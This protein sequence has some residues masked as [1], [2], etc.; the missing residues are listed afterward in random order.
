MRKTVTALLIF[1]VF[2]MILPG[3]AYAQPPVKVVVDGRELSFDVPPTIEGNRVLVPFRKIGEAMGVVVGWNPDTRTVYGIKGRVRV[4]LAI[5][6]TYA[7][8]NGK[9][10][11]L[12]VPAVIRGNRTLVPLRFFSEAFGA[13]VGW[14]GAGRVVTIITAYRTPAGPV[15]KKVLGYYYSKS[16][17]DF[18]ANF[19]RMTHAAFKWYTLDAAGNLTYRD[20]TRWIYV[21]EGYAEVL[22]TAGDNKVKTHALVFE[23]NPLRL[24][25][26]LNDEE[27]RDN[28][29]E[30]IVELA[31][32]GGFNGVDIDF[33]N[34]RENDR[35]EFNK[36]IE[37]LASELHKKDKALSISL[38]VKTEKVD[39]H[40]AYDYAELGKHADL[41]I[42]MAYDKN[43]A[44]PEPQAA[45]G[46]VEEVVDYAVARI[47]AEKVLLGIGFYGYNWSAAGRGTV[48]LT[49][50]DFDSGVQFVDELVERYKATP[51]WD[52]D[53]MMSTFEYYDEWG[54]H[55]IVWYEDEK[56][57]QAKIDLVKNKNIGG[58]ALWRLGYITPGAWK[59]IEQNFEIKR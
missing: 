55:H 33:E 20:D 2:W 15:A 7:L 29:I 37:K 54:R 6:S 4:E 14:D 53:A 5:E 1:F 8:V 40:K 27:K 28:L 50:Q 26:V 56:S 16:Y 11:A 57:L 18:M 13:E 34:I 58:I 39:W 45:I 35:E 46:W 36:F 52:E 31:V 9:K 38:P 22:K 23:N 3:G 12:D 59:I 41:L 24:Q 48:L 51:R 43:P 32:I 44:S 25:L 21:P 10:V 19:S 49:R 47:P 30:Q 42:L 17:S